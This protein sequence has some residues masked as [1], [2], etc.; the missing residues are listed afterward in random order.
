[1]PTRYRRVELGEILEAGDKFCRRDMAAVTDEYLDFEQDCAYP[2]IKMPS[3]AVGSTPTAC[4]RYWRKV[5]PTN[6][7][8]V[9]QKHLLKKKWKHDNKIPKN[10]RR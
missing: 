6:I 3:W 8:I 1:M 4:W 9:P 7:T 5:S 2:G 10:T